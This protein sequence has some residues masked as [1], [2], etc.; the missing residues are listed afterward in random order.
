[1]KLGYASPARMLGELRPSELGMWQAM[2]VVDP[3]GEER[4]DLRAGIVAS[5]IANWAGKTMRKGETVAPLDYMPLVD[6]PKKKSN[7]SGLH[8]FLKSRPTKKAT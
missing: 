2:Y 3:W 7:L 5:S 4:G 1:M 6:H 8:A